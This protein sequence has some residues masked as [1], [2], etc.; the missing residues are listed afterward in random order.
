MDKMY[1]NFDEDNRYFLLETDEIL[2]HKTGC[3]IEG[4]DEFSNHA[5]INHFVEKI[6]SLLTYGFS[7][8]E[9]EN[10]A[11]M[12][13]EVTYLN[14]INTIKKIETDKN[15]VEFVVNDQ[16]VGLLHDRRN[17]FN[18]SEIV[19][20][21]FKKIIERERNELLKLLWRKDER[22]IWD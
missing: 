9:K 5:R 8:E 16:L 15:T 4:D 2:I 19:S 11:S 10:I 21:I 17:D 22:Q 14:P 7:P 6:A 18:N 13:T 1:E 20:I 3:S 12:C